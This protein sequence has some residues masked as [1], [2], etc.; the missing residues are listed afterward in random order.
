MIQILSMDDILL[1]MDDFKMY[2]KSDLTQIKIDQ[3][4]SVYNLEQ[5]K[6]SSNKD[7]I[8]REDSLSLIP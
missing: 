2:A 4:R 6:L 7:Q 8:L 1:Y 5:R 3:D